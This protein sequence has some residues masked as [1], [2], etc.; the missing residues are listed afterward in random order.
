MTGRH[1]TYEE[2][3]LYAREAAARAPEFTPEQIVSLR[4]LLGIDRSATSPETPTA[5]VPSP[6]V[7]TYASP[8]TPATESAPDDN[9]VDRD[10]AA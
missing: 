4:Q 5:G 2:L 9:P 10:E 3:R 7:V 6:A 8:T 1:W